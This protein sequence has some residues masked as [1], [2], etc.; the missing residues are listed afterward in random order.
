MSI[1]PIFTVAV[2]DGFGTDHAVEVMANGVRAAQETALAHL[3]WRA[4]PKGI[5]DCGGSYQVLGI[6]LQAGG[7]HA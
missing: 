5:G 1:L 2:R 6:I 3:K 4:D 7:H